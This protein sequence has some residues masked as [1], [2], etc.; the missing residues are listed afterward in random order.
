MATPT[1]EAAVFLEKSKSQNISQRVIF[2]SGRRGG[3]KQ[4][5]TK[6]ISGATS[7]CDTR[8]ADAC[9]DGLVGQLALTADVGQVA[10]GGPGGGD[11]AG[12]L[13]LGFVALD[14]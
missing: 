3:K 4:R 8:R 12:E 9:D 6:R 11:E 14:R 13:L 2:T 1:E 7:G 5:L 10:R